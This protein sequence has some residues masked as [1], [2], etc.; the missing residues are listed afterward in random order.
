MHG[1]MIKILLFIKTAGLAVLT[2]II[3]VTLFSIYFI[4][5]KIRNFKNNQKLSAG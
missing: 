3:S 2:F 5:K 4:S 1:S